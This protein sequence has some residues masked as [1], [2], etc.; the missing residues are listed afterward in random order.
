MFDKLKRL[1][2]VSKWQWQYIKNP[3]LSRKELILLMRQER[4]LYREIGEELNIT[5]EHA[6]AIANPPLSKGRMRK[7]WNDAK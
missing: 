7:E 2:T 1:F 6:R 4:M 5:G 3:K